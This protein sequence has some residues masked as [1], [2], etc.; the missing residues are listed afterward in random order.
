MDKELIEKLI[1]ILGYPTAHS[2]E[3]WLELNGCVIVKKD[4]LIKKAGVKV[5]E[6][7]GVK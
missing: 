7:L 4:D 3:L 6:E 5:V 1:A 2:L